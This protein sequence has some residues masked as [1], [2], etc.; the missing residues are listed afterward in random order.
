M[1][2]YRYLI[3]RLGWS[4][5]E[6]ARRLNINERTSRRYASGESQTP[7]SIIWKLLKEEQWTSSNGSQTTKNGGSKN[8]V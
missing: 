8:V 3:G 1:T 7:Q 2:T 5:V 4:Q 6:A